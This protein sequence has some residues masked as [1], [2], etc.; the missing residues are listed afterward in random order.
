MLDDARGLVVLAYA[1]ELVA[2]PLALAAYGALFGPE[3]DATLVIYAPGQGEQLAVAR[4]LRALE[5]AG[6]PADAGP[7][8][9]VLAVSGGEAAERTLAGHLDA[10]YS[11]RPLAGPL[12]E[13]PR[14]GMA[15]LAALR[16]LA[17]PAPEP[18]SENLSLIHISEPTRH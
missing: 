14:Y 11:R 18:P 15:D 17:A 6:I 7:D 12:G 9:L 4:V 13:V 1:D 8:M 5:M 16:V 2:E 3:D 10:V